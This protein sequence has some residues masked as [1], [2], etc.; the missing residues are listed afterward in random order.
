MSNLPAIVEPAL[1]YL[2]KNQDWPFPML[3][4]LQ[5]HSSEAANKQLDTYLMRINGASYRELAKHYEITIRAAVARVR[6][7]R[8]YLIWWITADWPSSPDARKRA[9]EMMV[10]SGMTE[11]KARVFLAFG[12]AAKVQWSDATINDRI[13]EL[14]NEG[15][16]LTQIATEVGLDRST[17]CRRLQR[18]R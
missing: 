18:M 10:E 15:K 2:K 16:S 17:V 6:K 9:L 5:F 3:E 8:N 11:A 14:R 4:D 1:V 12:Q 13:V 7:I